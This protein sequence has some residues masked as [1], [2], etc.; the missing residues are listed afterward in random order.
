[1]K[2]VRNERIVCASV[3]RALVGVSECGGKLMTLGGAQ[4]L[5]DERRPWSTGDETQE[6]TEIVWGDAPCTASGVCG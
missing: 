2:P 1:M 4:R 6:I 3:S 5:R